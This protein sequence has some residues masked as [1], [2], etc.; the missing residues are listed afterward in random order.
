MR[1]NRV[2]NDG[3]ARSVAQFLF[4]R[5][6][7]LAF[8]DAHDRVAKLCGMAFERQINPASHAAHGLKW[9]NVRRVNYFFYSQRVGGLPPDESRFGAV[10]VNHVRLEF[11]D[12]FLDARER[13]K[14][15]PRAYRT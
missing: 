3:E 9:Q 11:T 5:K 14:I 15:F 1:L 10:R 6:R 2:L 7:A 4:H 8:T 12:Q 13:G